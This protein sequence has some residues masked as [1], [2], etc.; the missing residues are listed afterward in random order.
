MSRNLVC[1]ERI[2]DPERLLCENL[3]PGHG[4]YATDT[5]KWIYRNLAGKIKKYIADEDLQNA[6]TEKFEP[7]DNLYLQVDGNKEQ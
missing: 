4:G 3:Q 5:K 2:E 1:I 6:R 7:H